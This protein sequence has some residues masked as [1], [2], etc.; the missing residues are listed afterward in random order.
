MTDLYTAASISGHEVSA[1]L[2]ELRRALQL[3]TQLRTDQSMLIR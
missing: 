3:E 2:E 1:A